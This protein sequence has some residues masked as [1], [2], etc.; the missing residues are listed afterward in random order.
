MIAN[1]IDYNADEKEVIDIALKRTDSAEQL[2][3]LRSS[4]M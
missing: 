4:T 1:P 3:R 2:G